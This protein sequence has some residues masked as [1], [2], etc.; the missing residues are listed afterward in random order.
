MRSPHLDTFSTERLT[1]ERL[2]PE[3]QPL[4][5]DHQ[6]MSTFSPDG[7]PLWY[8]IASGGKLKGAVSCRS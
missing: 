5:Q 7:Q 3:H 8:S 1:A 6:V 2:R 4:F